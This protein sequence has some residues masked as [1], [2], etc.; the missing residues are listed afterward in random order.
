MSLVYSNHISG[1]G[2]TFQEG[3]GFWICDF[4]FAILKGRF[5]FWEAL[6]TFIEINN[7]LEKTV[8]V[9]YKIRM[10]YLK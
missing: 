2:C 6:P 8:Y 1:F 4:G 7:S 9:P 3:S 5:P 10:V